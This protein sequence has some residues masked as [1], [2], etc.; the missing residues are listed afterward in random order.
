MRLEGSLFKL[1][2]TFLLSLFTLLCF[3]TETVLADDNN[4]WIETKNMIVSEGRK[5]EVSNGESY[6]PLMYFGDLKYASTVTPTS[7]ESY[8]KNGFNIF[9]P[10]SALLSIGV[11]N[12]ITD[13]YFATG[14]HV[15]TYANGDY[16]CKTNQNQGSH[17]SFV[18]SNMRDFDM[19]YRNKDRPA[20]SGPLSQEESGYKLKSIKL[21][22]RRNS[23][24]GLQDQK[25]TFRQ[26][27]KTNDE[28]EISI[29]LQF[30]NSNNVVTTISFKNVGNKTLENFDGLFFKSIKLNKDNEILTSNHSNSAPV[31]TGNYLRPRFEGKR[32]YFKDRYTSNQKLVHRGGY[33]TDPNNTQRLSYFFNKYID[34][35]KR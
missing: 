8:L 12:K 10:N 18:T 14:N 29:L 31:I 27:T 34:S 7:I 24:T 21:E 3:N 28:I 15:Y 11:G 30:N 9:T 17:R 20:I 19:R 4:D 22:Y 13:G 26:K 32:I 25:L 16:Q 6:V 35:P 23:D 5:I 33:I 2:V 1:V